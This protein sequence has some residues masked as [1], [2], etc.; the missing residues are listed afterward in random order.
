MFYEEKFYAVTRYKTLATFHFFQEEAA[1]TL[2]NSKKSDEIVVSTIC[3]VCNVGFT[4]ATI[5][6]HIS[7]SSCKEYYR[8]EEIWLYRE[9]T[10]EKIGKKKKQSYDPRKRREYREKQKKQRDNQVIEVYF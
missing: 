3:K 4:R 2:L 10:K 5:L 8:K 6:K 9:W 7:H 1:Q